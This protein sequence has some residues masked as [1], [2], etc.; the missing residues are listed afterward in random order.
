MKM[1]LNALNSDDYMPEI[2]AF[3]GQISYK[4]IDDI[5]K[6]LTDLRELLNDECKAFITGN[7]DNSRKIYEFS[8]SWG[9]N[10]I[11]FT[12]AQ[13][14]PLTN[15]INLLQNFVIDSTS[16]NFTSVGQFSMKYDVQLANKN[17]IDKNGNLK[18]FNRS[19]LQKHV[20]TELIDALISILK[21]KKTNNELQNEIVDMLGF[22]K[23]DIVQTIFENRKQ[24]IQNVEVDDKLALLL[25]RAA[26][27]EFGATDNDKRAIIP[28]VSSQVVVQSE[29]ELNLKKKVRKDEKKLKNLINAQN[30]AAELDDDSYLD[31]NS[32]AEFIASQIR[33]QQQLQQQQQ[34]PILT[35]E[36]P[37]ATPQNWLYQSAKKIK[38]PFVFDEQIEARSHV[39][40]IAGSKLILPDTV[41]R[42]DNKMYEE[43]SLPANTAPQCLNVG[44]EKIKITDLDEIGQLAFKGTKELN[45]IQ[46]VVFHRAYHNN[47]NLLVC[48]PT[49]AGKTN[50]AMLTIVNAIRSHTDQGVIHRDEFK[51]VYVAPMKALAAEMVANFSKRL[52]PLGKRF[53]IFLFDFICK[54]KIHLQ[55]S[56]FVN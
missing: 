12:P 46:S 43:V 34:Q 56:V 22:D 1:P 37:S 36:R 13:D 2:K 32:S 18:M 15:E 19:W 39:G 28:V 41:T 21:S 26:A 42:T 5:V 16:T 31:E 29:Q 54:R 10:D 40:F 24:I 6:V 38:Y 17:K 52:G 3:F 11:E 35:K 51:I 30:A 50:V 55:E 14:Q 53:S 7:I 47:D 25:E 9:L 48:A 49:G 27:V 20:N 44:E 45:R 8:K 33:L 4:M 23:L